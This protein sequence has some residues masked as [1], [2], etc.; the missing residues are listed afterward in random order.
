MQPPPLPT[1]PPSPPDLPGIA[2]PAADA[3]T[4]PDAAAAQA[5][6][7]SVTFQNGSA[8]LPSAAADKLK[9]LAARRGGGTIAVTGFGD[10]ASDDP[11]A[12]SAALALG[13]SRAQAIAG[14]LTSAG[15]PSSAVEVDAAAIGRGGTARLLP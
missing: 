10:A 5:N 1:T 9:Q 4:T 8:A 3:A 12:Q 14:T 13:L 6:S 2:R 15:V 7:V 11:N